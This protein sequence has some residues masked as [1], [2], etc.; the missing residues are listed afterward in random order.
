MK[1]SGTSS[2]TNGALEPVTRELKKDKISK[3]YQKIKVIDIKTKGDIQG[4]EG[5]K[6]TRYWTFS[7]AFRSFVNKWTVI[8]GASQ[9]WDAARLLDG[10]HKY[11]D[12]IGA[13]HLQLRNSLGDTI[14]A[15]YLDASK[16]VQKLT[17]LGGE[18]GTFRIEDER[19]LEFPG[20]CFNKNGPK[21]KEIFQR[22][23]AEGHLRWGIIEVGEKTFLV[24]DIVSE[25]SKEFFK[26]MIEA[27][28]ITMHPAAAIE[29]PKEGTVLLSMNQTNSY[30]QYSCE[31]LTLALEG[32]NVM[33]YNSAGKGLSQST[34]STPH[35]AEHINEA[36]ET[37]YQ[38]L[39]QHKGI[40]DDKIL[41]KGQCFGSAP[42]V[43]LGKEHPKINLMLDQA[44]ASFVDGA[45]ERV[46][47]HLKISKETFWGKFCYFI[48]LDYVIYWVAKALI[49]NFHTPENLA[50]NQGQV[51]IHNNLHG[52][53]DEQGE[54][55]G[56]DYLVTN[57][58]MSKLD[59]AIK[60]KERVTHTFSPGGLHCDH[61]Y[62]Q[63]NPKNGVMDFMKRIDIVSD[64]F[65]KDP[66]EIRHR[67]QL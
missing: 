15:T 6:P 11:L 49:E 29:N 10:R 63:N 24:K 16:V 28:R 32:V 13:E 54:G 26:D 31:M 5:A 41:A 57:D 39:T 35:T 19:G 7:K 65:K 51:L 58:D 8:S 33:A 4:Q 14:D 21:V 47:K 40:T 66:T 36:I 27:R 17:E 18:R 44:P 61:W 3:L 45:V 25:R 37:C 38:Y 20:Y 53:G 46:K 9:N 22:L 2:T 34:S 60:D 1:I 12:K 59:D 50:L 55:I 62:L 48:K 30:E 67:I 23:A 43:W 56:G 42:T 52:L 64:F